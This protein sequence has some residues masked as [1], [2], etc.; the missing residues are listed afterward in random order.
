MII[1]NKKNFNIIL[2]VIIIISLGS[3]FCGFFLNE[4]LSTGGS[5]WDFRLIWPIVEEYSKFNLT[6]EK[7]QIS[8][9]VPLHYLIL[10][11]FNFIFEEKN[12]VRFMYFL[13]SFSL[14]FFLYLNLKLIYKN[15]E[16]EIIIICLS[17][18][19]LPFFRS[20]AIWANAHL[21]AIIFFLISNYF[22]LLSVIKKNQNLK[23]LN[24]FFLAL[25]TYSIQSYVILYLFYLYRY[26]F[27]ET[28]NFFLILFFFS[29]IMGLP[30]LFF[31]NIN[32][33]I[34]YLPFS[35]DWF[36]NLSANLSLV[37]FYFL[38]VIMNKENF[39]IILNQVIKINFYEVLFLTFF[40]IVIATNLDY[41]LMTSSLKGG[42][43]FYKISHFLFSN[44]VFFISIVLFSLFIIFNIVSLQ[45]NLL[46]LIIIMN[47]MS[48]GVFVYQKY[49]EPFFLIILFTINKNYLIENLLL[50]KKNALI[51]YS[52]LLIY[53]LLTYLNDILEFSK[54][55]VI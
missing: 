33:R 13:F 5:T 20:S 45:K 43:F 40:F 1:N 8:R 41:S 38:L 31:I 4:D 10:S 30:G 7:S 26:Y 49:F 32:P 52:I 14:P 29:C 34:V 35:Q 9:H 24:L 22:Y 47:L 6:S 12:S 3:F 39:K 11:F 15:R 36:F 28:F 44:N 53:F 18:F 17:L 2:S 51:F 37:F 50:N 16:Y 42:G 23:F 21:T 19:L 46:E 25:S 55:L 27:K 48:I 54:K